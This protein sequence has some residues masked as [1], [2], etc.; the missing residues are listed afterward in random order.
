MPDLAQQLEVIQAAVVKDYDENAVREEV[1]LPVLKLLGYSRGG[2]SSRIDPPMP[3]HRV[4]L[5]SEEKKITGRPDY[6]VS[7][8]V[9]SAFVVEAK[10][11]GRALRDKDTEQAEYYALHAKVQ[12]PLCLV[13]NGDVF[14]V[15][16]VAPPSAAERHVVSVTRDR[17]VTDWGLLE[18]ALSPGQARGLLLQRLEA[19]A[20]A[21]VAPIGELAAIRSSA[22]GTVYELRPRAGET[23]RG[24]IATKTP[25]ATQLLM[26]GLKE[27]GAIALPAGEF[28]LR[29]NGIDMRQHFG[30]T[31][32]VRLVP[33]PPPVVNLMMYA[34]PFLRPCRLS[35]AP[36]RRVDAHLEIG[37]RSVGFLLT[38]GPTQAHFA[39]EVTGDVRDALPVA[40]FLSGFAEGPEILVVDANTDEVVLAS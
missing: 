38:V 11:A 4:M 13:S 23:L 27:H 9:R 6:V 28:D 34:G 32:D 29:M 40:T 16:R 10:K 30:A 1:L 20:R 12:A 19:E 25:H 21:I 15:F 36:I 24:E 35:A 3:L 33:H 14:E 8:D 31:G 39:L 2:T 22:E 7:V 37:D 26:E 17:L 18:A 5:G